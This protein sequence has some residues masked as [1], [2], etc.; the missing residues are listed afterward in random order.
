MTHKEFIQQVGLEIQV[1][2]LRR[3][4]TRPQLVKLT[5]LSKACIASIEGGKAGANILNYKRVTDAL[6]MK[7]SDLF[8]FVE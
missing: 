4:I 1:A 8:I 3:K 2:R 5:G 7:M 6:G